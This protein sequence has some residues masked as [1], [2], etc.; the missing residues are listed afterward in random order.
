MVFT[1]LKYMG[2]EEIRK[3]KEEARLPKQKKTYRIPKK[4]VKKLAQEKKEKE[5]R[6]GED[7]EL[8]KFFDAARQMTI[9][10]I[11]MNE[12]QILALWKQ[13]EGHVLRFA[14]LVEYFY[15]GGHV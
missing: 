10:Q 1:K 7:T 3:L 13:S 9:G 5:D 14:K 6:G 12:S 4:S 2:L 8:Q 15:G 11:A